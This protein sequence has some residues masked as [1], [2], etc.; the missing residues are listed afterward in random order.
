MNIEK[1]QLKMQIA[2]NI[3]ADIEDRVEGELRAA[4]ELLGAADALQQAALKV[5]RDLAAKVDTALAEGEIK[6]MTALEAAEFAKKYLAKAGDYLRHLSDVERSKASDQRSRVAG[7]KF[8]MDSLQKMRDE[9]AQRIQAVIDATEED[10]EAPR[11]EASAARKAHGSVADRRAAE[12]E[13]KGSNGTPPKKKRAAKKKAKKAPRKK[14][15]AL[16]AVKKSS[17]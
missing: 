1:S 15:T 13:A 4:H 12:A 5:P 14:P 11:T 17:G 9:E 8:A 3:G 7:L 16:K 10:G 2:N 6:D